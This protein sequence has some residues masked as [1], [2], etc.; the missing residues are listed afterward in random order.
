M[1]GDN[2]FNMFHKY[3]QNDDGFIYI[4]YN[5]EIHLVCCGSYKPAKNTI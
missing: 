5:T 2:L 1:S 4:Y 3:Y